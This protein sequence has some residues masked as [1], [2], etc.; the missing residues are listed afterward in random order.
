[1][2]WEG[3]VVLTLA[4][5]FDVLFGDPRVSY[6][7]V[8]LIGKMIAAWEGILYK[9]QWSPFLQRVGG[10]ILVFVSTLPIVVGSHLFLEGIKRLNYACYLLV[11]AAFLWGTF[12]LKSLGQAAWEIL[13]LLSQHDYT[14]ARKSLSLIVGRDTEHLEEKEIV[15]ATVETVA[16]NISDGI[17]APL[18]YFLLGGVPFAWGY[19]VVNTLDSMVGYRNARYL[20]F[21]W[22]AAR[23]DDLANLLP[24]RLTAVFIIIAAFLWKKDWRNA[25]K[26]VLRD[27]RNHPSPNSGYP[28]AA[29]AGA[30][31]VQLGGLN[32]YQGMPSWRP[33]IG[34]PFRPLSPV[35]IKEVVQVMRLAV[36]FFYLTSLAFLLLKCL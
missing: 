25:I 21:G 11:S 5:I 22:C 9:E 7:P 16:E 29:V 12:S 20:H 32:Y 36:L 2:D 3:F 6:H 17:I 24:S 31:G 13:I 4:L 30:L 8:A 33:Y 15:R 27:A 18:F 1:M 14:N 10:F 26:T 35:H 19:R 23:L 28:E 34:D